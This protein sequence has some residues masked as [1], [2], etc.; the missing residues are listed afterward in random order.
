MADMGIVCRG[1]IR[2]KVIELEM[3]PGLREGA[4]VEVRISLALSPQEALRRAS[5]G[6]DDDPEGLDRWLEETRRLR[7]L[8]R[9]ES[10]P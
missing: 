1:V 4:P 9:R 5:G 6:W 2:G 10:P 8:E 3:D 7:H